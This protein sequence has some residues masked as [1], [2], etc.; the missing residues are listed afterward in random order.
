VLAEQTGSRG[1]LLIRGTGRETLHGEDF[2][3]TDLT[4]DA[5]RVAGAVLQP[6]VLTLRN[7]A[8]LTHPA[9]TLDS[10]S[11][12][13]IDVSTLVIDATS[14]IDVTDRG[15]LGGG[16]GDNANFTQGRTVGNQLGSTLRM[17]GSYGGLGGLGVLPGTVAPVYGNPRDPNDTGS[18][19][20][21][22]NCGFGVGGN[23]GGGLVRIAADVADLDGAIIAD[24]GSNILA[25]CLGGGSGGGIKV[26]AA[27]LRGSGQMSATGGAGG[28][29]AGGG[30]G[31]RIAVFYDM[32]DGFALGNLAATGGEGLNDGDDGTVV[33]EAR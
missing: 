11:S 9:A 27:T 5:A 7:G 10:V 25:R 28:S 24:G 6:E 20:G 16:A 14:A 4:V 12:L 26:E 1:H 32:L 31:G 17:G 18:G 8:V 23:S 22:T 21:G 2:A 33:T 19:G 29:S 3:G 15:F 13:A 30:G